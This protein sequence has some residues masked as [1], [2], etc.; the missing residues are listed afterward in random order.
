MKADIS[1]EL[2]II[3]VKATAAKLNAGRS[4]LYTWLDIKSPHYK[5]DLPKP[6]HLGSSAGFIEY[7]IDDY[8][9]GLMQ[10][11]GGAA[12]Q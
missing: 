8:I 7:E 4:T 5:P 9:R 12:G 11:R 2:R 3:S 6:V 10:A 1:P